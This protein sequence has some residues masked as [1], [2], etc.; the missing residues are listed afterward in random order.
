MHCWTLAGAERRCDASAACCA[1]AAARSNPGVAIADLHGNNMT[2]SLTSDAG[3]C[4]GYEMKGQ[5]SGPVVY[6]QL[7][8]TH[9]WWMGGVFP[10]LMCFNHAHSA[11]GIADWKSKE[12][13]SSAIVS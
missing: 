4:R 11:G 6:K 8:R 2:T 10:R 12:L 5:V 13:H 3:T 7:A 9:S 1:Q